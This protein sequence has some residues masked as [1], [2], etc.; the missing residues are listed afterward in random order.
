MK[1][2]L[3]LETA[4]AVPTTVTQ[5]R[6]KERRGQQIEKRRKSP[7]VAARSNIAVTTKI[8]GRGPRPGLRGAIT[9]QDRA[10]SGALVYLATTRRRGGG[11]AT[12]GKSETTPLTAVGHAR[13]RGLPL[14]REIL[15]GGGAGLK[16]AEGTCEM[17]TS[18]LGHVAALPRPLRKTASGASEG[19]AGRRRPLD[20][21]AARPTCSS[22]LRKVPPSQMEPDPRWTS[23]S[24]R[25][26]T[27][28][29][30]YP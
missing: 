25:R 8:C 10:P 4:V 15:S 11:L 21:T 24:H 23:T 7:R 28:R 12:T 26:T 6:A 1:A 18:A 22:I 16:I 2:V 20:P 29:W 13:G 5:T 9:R 3:A 17:S 30:M 27:R 19:G 14:R